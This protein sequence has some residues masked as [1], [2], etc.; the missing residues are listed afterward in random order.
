MK[1]PFAL[2]ERITPLM[3][4][5]T[6]EEAAALLQRCYGEKRFN[7]AGDVPTL[8]R[9]VLFFT[10]PFLVFWIWSAL[11]AKPYILNAMLPPIGILGLLGLLPELWR[12]RFRRTIRNGSFF[13]GRDEA[14]ILR[15]ARNT[16]RDYNRY[17][18]SYA[19]VFSLLF[20]DR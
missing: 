16:V 5:E 14:E 15:F 8:L 20:P 9:A 12:I 7:L 11:A 4:P 2:P 10:V 17:L 19:S 1:N 18:S 6:R 13:A 3:M